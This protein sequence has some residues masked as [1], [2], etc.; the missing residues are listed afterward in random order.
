[1][2]NSPDSLPVIPE[3][4]DPTEYIQRVEQYLDQLLADAPDPVLTDD[5]AKYLCSTGLYKITKV[6][7]NRRSRYVV[8]VA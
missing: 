7:L 6:M 8:C 3:N 1:M 4:N 2:D 5:Q